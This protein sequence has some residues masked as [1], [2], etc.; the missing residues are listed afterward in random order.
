MTATAIPEERVPA[1]ATAYGVAALFVPVSDP[2]TSALWYMRHFGLTPSPNTPLQPEMKHVILHCSG[3]APGLFLLA[4]D[5]LTPAQ[6]LRSGDELMTFCLL[7]KDIEE[8]L[9]RLKASGVR[10]ER[11]TVLDRGTCGLNVKCY[12]PDGNKFE[13]VQPAG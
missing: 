4:C 10:L 3:P 8:A 1:S 5:N 2:Y 7:V 9:S 12:D 13:I 6:R 11:D